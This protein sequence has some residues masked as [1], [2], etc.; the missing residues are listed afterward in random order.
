MKLEAA[1]GTNMLSRDLEGDCMAV[2]RK[3]A[4]NRYID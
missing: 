1:S 4:L 2:L 3:N